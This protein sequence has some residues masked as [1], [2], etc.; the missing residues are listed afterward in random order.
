M[1]GKQ[2]GYNEAF[3]NT[4]SLGLFKVLSNLSFKIKKKREIDSCVLNIREELGLPDCPVVGD[5]PCN[6]G[7]KGLIPGLRK[8]LSAMGQLSPC[9]IAIEAHTLQQEETTPIKAQAT[10]L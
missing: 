3:L 8:I 9:A 5:P 2:L 4:P 1:L 7:D 10:E 6:T